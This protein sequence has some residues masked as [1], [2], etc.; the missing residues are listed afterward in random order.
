MNTKIYSIFPAC[1]KTWLYE[2]QEDYGLKILDSDSS[3]FSWIRCYDA[4]G[5][6]TTKLRNPD[7]PNNYIKHI[8]ENI[9]K[10]DCIFV[11]SH[12]SV[13][14]AL[15]AEGIDYEFDILLDGEHFARITLSVPGRHNVYNALA[16]AGAA[17]Q[18]GGSTASLLSKIFRLTIEDRKIIIMC[19][20]SAVFAG[21]FGTPLTAAIFC[22]EFES[23]GTLFSP[24]LLPCYLA[25]FMASRVSAAQGVHAETFFLNETVP[26]TFTTNWQMLVLAVL[27]AVV[28]TVISSLT[29]LSFPDMLVKGLLTPVRTGVSKLADG[30]D[31][32]A[33][34]TQLSDNANLRWNI[35]TAAEEMV[36]ENEGNTVFF[37]MCPASFE[38]PEV[39]GDEGLVEDFPIDDM[40]AAEGEGIV[41]G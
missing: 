34:K 26:F 35:C 12:K 38:Q 4:Y 19:G 10:Y 23:V 28:L 32:E 3:E 20:M 7:F 21:L 5:R 1:G 13:R 31:V 15:N 37:L 27:I 11:S 39:E 8:K 22:M 17:L 24:A 18:L 2:H 40:P 16:A 14:E 30:A 41:L 9:G 25:A 6:P 33:F 36:I 29:G